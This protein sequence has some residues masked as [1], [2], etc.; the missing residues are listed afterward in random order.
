VVVVAE[1]RKLLTRAIT[2]LRELGEEA[3]L[4]ACGRGCATLSLK[5]MRCGRFLAWFPRTSGQLGWRG[6]R[7]L[8]NADLTFAR[9]S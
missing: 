5:A 2:S 6:V 4:S 1:L 9:S 3:L 7:P 8:E